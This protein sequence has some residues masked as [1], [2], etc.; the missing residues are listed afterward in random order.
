MQKYPVLGKEQ[1]YMVKYLRN[2]SQKM[3]PL[4]CLFGFFIDLFYFKN[5]LS[6]YKQNQKSAPFLVDL[7][8]HSYEASFIYVLLKQNEK[9]LVMNT[10]R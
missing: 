6:K 3:W 10:S 1:L 7:F 9:K 5:V 2:G 4:M 8:L